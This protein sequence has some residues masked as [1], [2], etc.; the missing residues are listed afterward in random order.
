[1]N[2]NRTVPMTQPTPA[3][4]P[5]RYR[6]GACALGPFLAAATGRGVCA[7]LFG[8]DADALRADLRD[9]FPDAVLTEADDPLFDAVA[10]FLDAARGA[11]DFPL[12]PAGT[13]F[14][15]EVWEALRTVPAGR[16]AS[17]KE[18]ALSIGAPKAVRAVARACAGNPIAVA[19]PCHRIVRSDGAMSG[20]RWGAARKRALL[21]REARA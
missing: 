14:Q 21:D 3:A 13:D 18:I 12:D 2:A 11:P 1:M 4:D 6:I 9:R 7:I 19:I 20:Y 10:R 16:T 15:R 5:I 17:Y 8:D